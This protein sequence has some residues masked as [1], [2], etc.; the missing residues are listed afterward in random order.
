MKKFLIFSAL[1]FTLCPLP[2]CGREDLD[3]TKEIQV[4]NTS[5][6]WTNFVY[7]PASYTE[8]EFTDVE[9]YDLDLNLEKDR[10][11]LRTLKNERINCARK[12]L[13]WL[14]ESERKNITTQEKIIS[15]KEVWERENRKREKPS[16]YANFI[17][18][19]IKQNYKIS[20]MRLQKYRIPLLKEGTDEADSVLVSFSANKINR[21]RAATIADIKMFTSSKRKSRL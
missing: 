8:A 3:K 5:L 2:S 16:F 11:L 20:L 19:S 15:A 6:N 10:F 13:S 14:Y 9:G 7:D 4:V 1:L 17:I 21:L 12:Y 18:Y